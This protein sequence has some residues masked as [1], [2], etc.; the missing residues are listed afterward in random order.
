MKNKKLIGAIVGGLL[1]ILG[2]FK[3]YLDAPES[4]APKA[5][6]AVAAP[7]GDAGL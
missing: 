2:A 6:S 3:V 4:P 7:A 1:A 5:P